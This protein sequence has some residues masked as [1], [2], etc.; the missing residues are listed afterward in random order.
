VPRL[1]SSAIK[2]APGPA[3]LR[4]GLYAAAAARLRTAPRPPSTT[5]P[6]KLQ[7]LLDTP[8]LG[9][10]FDQVDVLVHRPD[11]SEAKGEDLLQ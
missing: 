3:S 6:I 7:E 1:L 4:R 5:A 10:H 2:Q 11:S 9:L 8:D